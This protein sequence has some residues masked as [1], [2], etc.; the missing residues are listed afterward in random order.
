MNSSFGAGYDSPSA[1][2]ALGGVP[3]LAELGLELGG[4]V[5]GMAGLG[6]SDEDER[7]RRLGIVVNILKVGMGHAWLRSDYT[8]GYGLMIVYRLI[9]GDSAKQELKGW[10]DEW[11]WSVYGKHIWA[12]E[13][14]RGH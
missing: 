14:A 13:A 4:G 11:D 7:K 5:S 2:M 3:G 8:Q 1:A 9:R 10:L 12:V 6:R